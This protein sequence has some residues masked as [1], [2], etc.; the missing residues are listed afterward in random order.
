ML[1][2]VDIGGIDRTGVRYIFQEVLEGMTFLEERS[3]LEKEKVKKQSH[4]YQP[5]HLTQIT[6]P[7]HPSQPY[8]QSHPLKEEQEGEVRELVEKGLG[9][10]EKMM[11]GE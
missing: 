9:K 1:V 7:T 8:Q 2:M 6:H 10:T 11:K 3:K 5:S 4:P